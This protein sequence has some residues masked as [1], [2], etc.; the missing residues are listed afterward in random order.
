MAS[1]GHLSAAPHST[2]VIDLTQDDNDTDATVT[3]SENR[4][5]HAVPIRRLPTFGPR[6]QQEDAARPPKRQRTGDPS[7]RLELAAALARC[8]DEQVFPHIER[9]TEQLSPEIYDIGTIAGKVTRAI[10]TPEFQRSFREGGGRLESSV[11]STIAAGI[12]RLVIELARVRLSKCGGC[13]EKVL[14]VET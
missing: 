10:V 14:M 3:N 8:L 5:H 12:H 9:A 6:A 1:R 13:I 4:L 7:Q 2:D 11:E